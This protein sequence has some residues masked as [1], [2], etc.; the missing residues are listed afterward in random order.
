[1]FHKNIR[2]PDF[3]VKILTS[4]SSS[5]NSRLYSTMPQVSIDSSMFFH[6]LLQAFHSFLDSLHAGCIRQTHIAFTILTKS[7]TRN[8]SNRFFTRKIL[9]ESKGI[10]I[11]TSWDFS[12]NIKAP[13]G[14]IISNPSADICSI[15]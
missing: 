12:K 5:R 13:S 1:M 2:L 9:Q 8:E 4:L 11:V 3:S 6:I 10:L 7:S 14:L 15:I